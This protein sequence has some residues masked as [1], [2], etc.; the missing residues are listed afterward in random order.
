MR[1]QTT[2]PL[3]SVNSLTTI[4]LPAIHGAR[5][6]DETE[7]SFLNAEDGDISLGA[8]IET[9]Q[10]GS[11]DLPGRVPGGHGNHLFQGVPRFRIA[12]MI[13]V[14]DFMPAFMLPLCRS[15]EMESGGNP[16][17][18]AGTATYQ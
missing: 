15:V 16:C 17:W 4:W 3:R 2:L 6:I 14:M 11:L 7:L 8:Y 1:S 13:L 12:D 18:M 5:G 10:I 9:A